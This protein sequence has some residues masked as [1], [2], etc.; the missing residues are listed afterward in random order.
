MFSLDSNIIINFREVLLPSF[1]TYQQLVLTTYIIIYIVLVFA[2]RFYKLLDISIV[3]SVVNNKKI[4]RR[5]IL[6]QK[7]EWPLR[8]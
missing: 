8:V 3:K 5:V 6:L 7:T 4:R 2:T 1:A